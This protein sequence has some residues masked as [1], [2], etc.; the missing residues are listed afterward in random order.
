MADAT[1]GLVSR[2]RSSHNRGT[3]TLANFGF[4]GTLVIMSAGV[5]LVQ[6]FAPNPAAE[7]GELLNRHT[8]P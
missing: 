5:A 1:K 2:I 6:K 3:N 4:K 8:S 7:D